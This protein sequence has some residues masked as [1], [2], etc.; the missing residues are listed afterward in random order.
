[1]AKKRDDDYSVA[2]ALRAPLGGARVA[3]FDPE[4]TPEYPGEGKAD[5]D[6]RTDAMATELADLQERLY[7]EGR[8]DPQASRVLLVLQG[9][10]TSGKGGVIR[11]SVG[12]VDPQGVQITGFKRPT[13]E[14]ASH[15]FLWR[16]RRALPEPG[17]I[18]VFDRSHYEDVLVQRVEQ[19]VPEDVWRARY[20]EINQF[21]AELA[22]SGVTIIKCYLNMSFDEQR[23]RLLERL[24]NPE[25]HWKYNPG[26]VDTR[27]KWDDYMAA[28]DDVLSR[29]TTEVAPWYVIPSDRKWYRNWAVTRLLLEHLRALDPQ[30]PEADFDVEAEKARLRD[31]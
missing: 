1:M 26:D 16:I 11:H 2:Q 31:S 12:L 3:D 17:K 21:E 5:A 18:G 19:I 14:E 20:D 28:Y 8:E 22:E 27:A 29:C 24:E 4:A 9:L 15:H 25:K 6:E 23:R 10:D 30:W 7:A 13:D